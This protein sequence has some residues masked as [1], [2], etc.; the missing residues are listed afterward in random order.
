MLLV[1]TSRYHVEDRAEVLRGALT[2]LAG[3]DLAP[4]DGD[5]AMKLRFR[6]WDA[7]DGCSLLHAQSSGFHFRRRPLRDSGD[8]R[9]VIGFSMMPSGSARFSQNDRR[10]TVP[11]DGLFIAEMG[12]A[13]DC[14]FAPCSEGI[15]LMVPLEVLDVPLRDVRRAAEGLPLSPVYPLAREHLLSMVRYA[16]EHDALQPSAH[17]AALHVLRA[18]VKSFGA[19]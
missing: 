18:L 6:A 1:D 13:F 15:N 5:T 11:G 16:C 3:V 17:Q 4:L 12:E 10:E 9:P 8:E 7:G 14:Q 19:D 2:E